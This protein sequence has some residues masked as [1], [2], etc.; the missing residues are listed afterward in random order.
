MLEVLGA[1][2]PYYPVLLEPHSLNTEYLQGSLV[3]GSIEALRDAL[4]SGAE[5]E[6]SGM[7]NDFTSYDEIPDP[8]MQIPSSVKVTVLSSAS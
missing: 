4:S 8:A 6:Q 1:R 2:K 7:L 3:Y 5:L